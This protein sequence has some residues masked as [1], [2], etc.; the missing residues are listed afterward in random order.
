[1]SLENVC[2]QND[3]SNDIKEP[4]EFT[5]NNLDDDCILT[6]FFYLPPIELLKIEEGIINLPFILSTN[7]LT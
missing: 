1:M 4:N 6:I 2:D 3:T 7:F 5:I